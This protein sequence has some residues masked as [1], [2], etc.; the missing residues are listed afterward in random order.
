MRLVYFQS[1]HGTL[2]V[3]IQHIVALEQLRTPTS[4]PT[5]VHL[6]TGKAHD[7]NNSFDDAQRRVIEAMDSEARL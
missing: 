4:T 7:V 2:A 5:R 1:T 3:A 6:T